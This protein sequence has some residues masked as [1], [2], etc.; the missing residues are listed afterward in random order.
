M[1]EQLPLK[2]KA[3]RMEDSDSEALEN[4]LQSFL[5]PVQANPEFVSR[6][7]TRLITQPSVVM[8]RRNKMAAFVV[9]AFGL[10]VGAFLVWAVYLVRSIFS[11]RSSSA[12]S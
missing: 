12:V 5:N 2:R 3:Y 11:R 10:F 1:S 7:K 6:L 9:A 4:Q 8:E